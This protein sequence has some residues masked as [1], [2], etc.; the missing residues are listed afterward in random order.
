MRGETTSVEEVTTPADYGISPEVL[1]QAEATAVHAR[2]YADALEHFRPFLDSLLANV[3]AT[4]QAREFV[5]NVG[6]VIDIIERQSDAM[7]AMRSSFELAMHVQP[8]P[9][10]RQALA[11][12]V[13]RLRED[14][15]TAAM[16]IA[17]ARDAEPT[18]LA[19]VG[20][21]LTPEQAEE[22][23]Q[24]ADEIGADP[25]LSGK[26]R[27]VAERVDWS[28]IG[29]LTPWAA[30]CAASVLLFKV[31]VLP[32]TEQF[33]AEQNAVLSNWFMALT[34]I[35]ALATIIITIQKK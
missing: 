18:I 9:E 6:P 19:L 14:P 22:I 24:G 3:A 30:L 13:H 12:M 35:V 28:T 15:P 16:L 8:P 29:A 10:T 20:Q 26:L 32:V 34:V 4:R 11:D 2:P 25:E 23:Q 31:A 27:R 21:E 17:Q 33:S 1:A 5:A 7:E